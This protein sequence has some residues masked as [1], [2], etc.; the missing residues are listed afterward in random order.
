M[1]PDSIPR[2][3]NDDGDATV[4]IKTSTSSTSKGKSKMAK[5]ATK[6]ETQAPEKK[7]ARR[8]TRR[9]TA[10]AKP[11]TEQAKPTNEVLLNSGG[12]VVLKPGTSHP[13]HCY[14][15]N[16]PLVDS[17]TVNDNTSHL[18]EADMADLLK[19][20]G[21][22]NV[23]LKGDASYQN[24]AFL[25]EGVHK[26][27]L[28]N[29]KFENI[30]AY[31]NAPKSLASIQFGR[32]V[33]L[34]TFNK[35]EELLAMDLAF[36]LKV[37]DILMKNGSKVRVNLRI[38]Q[39]IITSMEDN[40]VFANIFEAAAAQECEAL[41]A[42]IGRYGLK[43]YTLENSSQE[44]G[45]KSLPAS[46]EKLTVKNCPSMD[47]SVQVPRATALKDVLITDVNKVIEISS[48]TVIPKVV[49]KNASQFT[50][51]EALCAKVLEVN[52]VKGVDVQS[53]DD[54]VMERFIL[55]NVPKLPNFNNPESDYKTSLEI[56]LDALMLDEF[57]EVLNLPL[58]LNLTMSYMR[59][60][61]GEK[62][63]VAI[64]V[65]DGEIVK[66]AKDIAVSNLKT[67]TQLDDVRA[68]V[69]YLGGVPKLTVEGSPIV[70]A[71]SD[72]DF[73]QQFLE[74]K[75]C[76]ELYVDEKISK[77]SSL[78]NIRIYESGS[79]I[80]LDTTALQNVEV[81]NIENTPVSVTP[82]ME[83]YELR[84]ATRDLTIE[85]VQ[86]WGS[87]VRNVW[88]NRYRGISAYTSYE[89]VDAPADLL[90]KLPAHVQ[91]N[92][93]ASTYDQALEKVSTVVEG[94][95]QVK[96]AQLPGAI[97]QATRLAVHKVAN[98]NLVNKAAHLLPASL[99]KFKSDGTG[100]S[101]EFESLKER[102]DRLAALENKTAGEPEDKS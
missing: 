63:Y 5:P 53:L 40:I 71:L 7:T 43:R 37:K 87:S 3:T 33:E 96:W 77:N 69:E 91:H 95:K 45:L 92:L 62:V 84:L 19:Q 9:T 47:V 82:N 42:F 86:S 26:L 64:E 94:L 79:V 2:K 66:K 58:K 10:K 55:T 20:I 24:L 49:V 36:D 81:I 65:Q 80:N 44:V 83:A 101:V 15:G 12:R 54:T 25:P 68:I 38:E 29:V 31:T 73:G 88:L 28:S 35:L 27:D 78:T 98:S 93:K 41:L 70:T 59:I 57:K 30:V 89:A 100:Y 56:S 99:P 51:T 72:V 85:S 39:G 1:F 8:T 23:L 76:K 17:F 11:A 48:Q 13:E 14:N 90:A 97:V 22:K 34:I 32:T 16:V 52:G 67:V 46:V 4:Q 61:G 102:R 75:S 74:V 60:T 6:T 50:V 18:N 21:A